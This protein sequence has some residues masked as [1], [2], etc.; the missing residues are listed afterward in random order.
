LKYSRQLFSGEEK[1]IESLIEPKMEFKILD[2]VLPKKHL[3]YEY[4]V[5]SNKD[6]F[7]FWFKYSNDKYIKCYGFF[8]KVFNYVSRIIIATRTIEEIIFIIDRD[9]KKL[10][11]KEI[12]ILRKHILG[13]VNKL[14][15]MKT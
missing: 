12:N 1:S 2:V 6:T 13:I 4:D 10:S 3:L 7:E 11:K 5:Y 8:P 9:N 15:K 14:K